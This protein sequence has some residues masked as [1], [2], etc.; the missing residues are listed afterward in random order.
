MERDLPNVWK[1]F[2]LESKPVTKKTVMFP[3]PI[4]KHL[5]AD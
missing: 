1:I 4:F 2:M 3:M 5:E